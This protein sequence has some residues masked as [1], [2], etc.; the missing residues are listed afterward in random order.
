MQPCDSSAVRLAAAT[1]VP[2]MLTPFTPDPAG[3]Q[4]LWSRE[5]R[6]SA[7]R[8][9][10]DWLHPQSRARLIRLPHPPVAVHRQALFPCGAKTG[11][12][13]PR[14]GKGSSSII[15]PAGSSHR[16]SST[17]SCALCRRPPAAGPPSLSSSSSNDSSATFFFCLLGRAAAS[18]SALALQEACLHELLCCVNHPKP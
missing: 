2:C 9:G 1:T 7:L 14:S 8:P 4:L 3:T 15:N 13:R 16:A 6:D 10:C 12:P 11:T 18:A 5:V 17:A